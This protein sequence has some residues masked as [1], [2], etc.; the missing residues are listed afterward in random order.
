VGHAG[1][2]GD[3]F[4]HLGAINRTAYIFTAMANKNAYP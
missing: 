2:M 1:H 3:G 4:R